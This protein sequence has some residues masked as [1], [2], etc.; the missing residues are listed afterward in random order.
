MPHQRLLEFTTGE[1]VPL[2]T[3]YC[4][5]RNYADHIREMHAAREEEPVVFLKSPC[6]YVPDGGTIVPPRMG[7]VLHHEVE[8][9]AVIGAVIHRVTTE[10]AQHA[11]V[12][13]GVGIDATLRDVQQHAKERG[14]PWEKAK[15]FATSAPISRIIPSAAIPALEETEMGLMVNGQVR[16]QAVAK[17]M[18]WSVPELVMYLSQWFIL[19]PGDVI[20]T[21]TPAGVGPLVPGDRVYAWLGEHVTLHVT[22]EHPPA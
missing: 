7:H 15:A 13:Y 4:I 2:G 3:I 14:L 18:I 17:Q 11:I 22:V 8:I 10:Q 12:G 20:F 6:A 16:Q 21:G 19:E 1:R 5:G 9:V